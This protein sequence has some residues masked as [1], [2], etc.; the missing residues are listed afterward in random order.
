MSEGYCLDCKSYT[1]VVLDHKA[2]DV[3]CSE[4]GLVL[5]SQLIDETAEWRYFADESDNNIDP[6][7]VGSPLLLS[8][9]CSLVTFIA[10]RNDA[11]NR[12]TKKSILR[13]SNSVDRA[14]KTIAAMS[15]N[16]GLV[17][18]I[19]NYAKEL[20]EKSTVD[21]KFR[22]IKNSNAVMAACLSRRGFSPNIQGNCNGC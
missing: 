16:L 9:G 3:I 4:C 18:T 22:R 21:V 14:F 10:N 6:N 13:P 19:E 5:E 7:R 11:L 8:D 2:G 12:W 1:P 17:E 15:D 20:Y